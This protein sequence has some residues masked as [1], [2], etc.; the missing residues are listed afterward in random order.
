MTGVLQFCRF[1]DIHFYWK[2]EL[3]LWIGYPF[4]VHFAVPI[5]VKQLL[6]TAVSGARV[7]A[8]SNSL[9]DEVVGVTKN[10]WTQEKVCC[11]LFKVPSRNNNGAARSLVSIFRTLLFVRFKRNNHIVGRQNRKVLGQLA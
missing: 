1:V 4:V 11:N 6:V 2:E 5:A 3:G 10:D 8:K 7:F 9:V